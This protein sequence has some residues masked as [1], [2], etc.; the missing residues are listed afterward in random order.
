MFSII[1][2]LLF[3]PVIFAGDFDT[4]APALAQRLKQSLVQNLTQKM[5]KDGAV[6]AVEFCHAEVKHIAKS[7]AGADLAKYEFGRTSHRIRNPQ[8]QPQAWMRPYLEAFQGSTAKAPSKPAI[9]TFFDGKKAYLEALYVGPQCLTCHGEA[10]GGALRE[11]ISN[12]YPA[13]QAT[14]FKLGE[15]RGLVW[16]KEK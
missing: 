5:A 1:L 4:E 8:N 9:H 11:K 13:D 6:A 16:V 2:F 10:V 14:G 3:S 12:L 15:F 7:A